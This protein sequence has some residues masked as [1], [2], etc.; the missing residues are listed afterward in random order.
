MVKLSDEDSPKKKMPVIPHDAKV[1]RYEDKVQ[2]PDGTFVTKGV[3]YH[4]GKG[5]YRELPKGNT[6]YIDG[7]KF[8]DWPDCKQEL[9]KLVK[10]GDVVNGEPRLRAN[11][12][13]NS[14]GEWYFDCTAEIPEENPEKVARL[15]LETAQEEE[16]KFLAAGKK[17]V[18]QP[19]EK[20]GV[21]Q[22]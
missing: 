6:V 8:D 18:D 22:E 15:C 2:K 21:K 10:G 4:Y 17:I 13:Q 11:A 20:G 12:K 9:K 16:N 19:A 1:G 14:K 5:Y 3:Y 7:R